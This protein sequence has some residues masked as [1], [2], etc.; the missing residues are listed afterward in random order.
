MILSGGQAWVPLD[1]S[2]YCQASAMS[3]SATAGKRNCVWRGSRWWWVLTIA[4]S[5][6]C[7]LMHCVAELQR[8]EKPLGQGCLLLGVAKPLPVPTLLLLSHLCNFAHCN[9]LVTDVLR[10]H[11][12]RVLHSYF[13]E[14]LPWCSL[15]STCCV[16]SAVGGCE[17]AAEHWCRCCA[18]PPAGCIIVCRTLLPEH[19]SWY[20]LLPACCVCSAAR[21]YESAA[22]HWCGCCAVPP[23]GCT[24][25]V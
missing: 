19:C 8:T 24:W 12:P 6:G 10:L 18:V 11:R 14:N 13:T 21:G 5:G 20:S 2:I 23:R 15:R 1:N 3:Y 4:S 9:A 22:E 25:T 16:C 17:P 7:K